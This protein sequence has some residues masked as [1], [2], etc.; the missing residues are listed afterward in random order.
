MNLQNNTLLIEVYLNQ[1]FEK[2]YKEFAG[3][4]DNL[5]FKCS[6]KVGSSN[7]KNYVVIHRV[8]F[9]IDLDSL[10]NDYT[11]LGYNVVRK[12]NVIEFSINYKDLDLIYKTDELLNKN[13]L[14]KVL[15]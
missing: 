4:S 5:R 14:K 3:I 2:Q 8:S 11:L 6:I 12:G 10:I 9:L 15:K 13:V 1:K 7:G